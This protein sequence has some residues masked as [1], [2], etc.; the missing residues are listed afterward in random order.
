MDDVRQ[1]SPPEPR[2]DGRDGSDALTDA[3]I[4][5]DAW[6]GLDGQLARE[7][8]LAGRLRRLALPLRV[9][10]ALTVAASIPIA[11]SMLMLRSDFATLSVTRAVLTFGLMFA[12]ATVAAVLAAW[13]VQLAPFS[14]T[15]VLALA[16]A[17]LALALVLALAPE[18]HDAE[19]A[20]FGALVMGAARCSAMGLAAAL[21]VGVVAHVLRRDAPGAMVGAG[22]LAGLTLLATLS[23]A[24]GYDSLGHLVLGH[25]APV[26]L[27]VVASLILER[28]LR[29]PAH[30]RSR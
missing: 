27:V 14:R 4:L 25:A 21:P 15:R 3:A 20:S 13:P 2:D 30:G 17:T 28:G 29:R 10:I 12:L 6:Q 5:A 11:A 19:P 22:A 1:P 8:G 9:G 7:R 16:G 26:A 23:L 24:C 18:L